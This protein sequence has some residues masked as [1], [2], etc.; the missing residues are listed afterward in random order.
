MRSCFSTF[1][2]VVLTLLSSLSATAQNPSLNMTELG[3]WNNPDLPTHSG[4]R[5]N[6]VWGY[7][8]CSGREYA[9]LGSA[10]RIHFIDVTKPEEPVEIQS[11]PGSTN[12]I[13]RDYKTYRDR[14]YACADQGADGLM[15]FDMSRLPDTVVMTYQ[16]N[17]VFQRSHN[18]WIDTLQ[19]RLYMAGTNTQGNG[20]IIYDLTQ[21][22]DAPQLLAS[23]PLPGGYIHDIHVVNNIAY[24]S[25]GFNGLWVYDLSD[26]QNIITLGSMTDYPE[27]GYNH[28]GWLSPDGNFFIMADETHGT[29]L[30]V[31]DVQD[32]DDIS[33]RSL[34]KSA[35]LAPGNLGSIVHNPFIRDQYVVM[36]YY[37][38]GIQIYDMSN[39]DTVVRAA[40]YDTYPI[41]TNYSGYDGAWGAYPYLPSGNILGSDITFGL[42]V[43][44][45]DSI[46]FQPGPSYVSPEAAILN[47]NPVLCEGASVELVAAPGAETYTWLFN[48][49]PIHGEDNVYLAAE[50]GFYQVLARNGHCVSRSDSVFL[51]F[52]G[53]PALKA[54]LDTPA[55]CE[56]D[57]ARLGIA[58][59]ADSIFLFREADGFRELVELSLQIFEGGV[60]GI[61]AHVGPCVFT[62][63]DVFEV[64]V[65]QPA[66]PVIDME[67]ALLNCTNAAQFTHFQWYLDGSPIAEADSA[68]WM[69]QQSGVYTLET[70]DVNGC[71]A[72]SEGVQVVVSSVEELL[73][74]ELGLFPNPVK[75]G[76]R[77]TLR[78][79]LFFE[80]STLHLF[81]AY[82]QTVGAQTVTAS[83]QEIE[84][85]G[86]LPGIYF[87]E[88][89][90][91][92]GSSLGRGKLVVQ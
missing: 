24:C 92:S 5:Y 18:L 20:V 76:Q 1:L 13:W 50:A 60:Y 39:P 77:L 52:V 42:F 11:F 16:N 46:Q 33:V 38:E 54:A 19:G 25:H 59:D 28:S 47:A 88:W 14:A 4:I 73:K 57:S 15:V 30:K 72:V 45:A 89:V 44:R 65:F 9:I 82:G 81:N 49:D 53:A 41:N 87:Y 70:V 91:G 67:G 12:S 23:V 83:Q 29:S 90:A 69:A 74:P 35:L 75:A 34:F 7:A 31:V 55:F 40:Y 21:N 22:P 66:E 84:T 64:T 79:N 71:Y 27:S 63:E 61:E 36:A 26:P 68:A 58:G 48:G 86:L 8:D 80:N 78:T 6:D 51:S 3:R 2:F 43:L 17:V 85:A 56:G 37:H 62:L 10:G 32:L